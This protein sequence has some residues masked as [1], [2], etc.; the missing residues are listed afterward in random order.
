MSRIQLIAGLGL[1]TLLTA[2]WDGS[3]GEQ[4]EQAAAA[5]DRWAAAVASSEDGEVTVD[6]PA[7]DPH[8][9]RPGLVP[10]AIEVSAGDRELLVRFTGSAAPA[11]EPCGADYRGE[12]VESD[13][14]VVVIIAQDRSPYPGACADIGAPRSVTIN[15]AAPL[16]DRAVLEVVSGTPLEVTREADAAGGG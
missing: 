10:D 4:R 11:N 13:L 16:A 2:C 12:A 15:L 5:L 1:A 9:P 3:I 7:W 6:P 14:A 8:D